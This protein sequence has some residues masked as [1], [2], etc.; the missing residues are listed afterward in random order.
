MRAI[1]PLTNQTLTRRPSVGALSQGERGAE[2]RPV[3][4][5]PNLERGQGGEVSPREV[6]P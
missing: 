3:S 5:S 6:L 4:P 2:G 1:Q